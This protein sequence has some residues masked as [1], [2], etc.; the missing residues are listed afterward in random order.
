MQKFSRFMSKLS[1]ACALLASVFLAIAGIVIIWM[2]SYRTM[3]YST[4]WELE[5]SIFLMVSSLFLASPYT[6]LTKGHVGVDLLAYYLK[7][8]VVKKLEWVVNVMGLLICLF[9]TWL[10]LEF[11]LES[12]AKGER[13]E[14]MW[15]PLK[16]PLYAMMPLGFSLTALQYIALMSDANQP[17]KAMS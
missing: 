5:L 15:G 4:S 17:K 12:F 2:V 9:L 7:P 3:G 14:S 10:C 1:A 6:L 16:W 11:T 13:T 8:A